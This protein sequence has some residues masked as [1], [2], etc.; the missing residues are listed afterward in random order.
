VYPHFE[1]LPGK[2]FCSEEKRHD[3]TKEAS[4]VKGVLSPNARKRMRRALNLLVAQALEKELFDEVSGR[5]FTFKVNFI[6]LELPAPQGD[7]TDDQLKRKCLN[8]WLLYAKRRYGLKSYVWKAETQENGNLHFHITTD[9]YIH[10]GDVRKSWNYSLRHFGFVEQYQAKMK[11][12]HKGG[13]QVRTDL[14]KSWNLTSQK[15]AY[16]YGQKTDWK[17]PNCTDV[18]AVNKIDDLAGYMIKYMSKKEDGRRQVEGKIWG[19]STNLTIKDKVEFEFENPDAEQ[20]R[21]A[22]QDLDGKVIKEERFQYLKLTAKEFD[23]YVTGE[24]RAQYES[25]LQKVREFEYTRSNPQAIVAEKPP[26]AKAT[27][28]TEMLQAIIHELPF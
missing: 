1:R 19:C 27:T 20:L 23:K 21:K 24:P 14:L 16:E 7:V 17:N 3:I 8:E 11:E 4:K 5:T 18:H 9:C 13:F 10:W 12:W 22:L 25:L 15:E 26:P 28:V 2:Q 6:T